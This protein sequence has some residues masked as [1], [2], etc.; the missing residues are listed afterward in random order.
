M[1]HL[2]YVHGFLSAPQSSKAQYTGAWLS[3]QHP[4]W[5]FHC[6]AVSSYPDVANG[7]IETLLQGLPLQ[8]TGLIG[9]SLG[10]FWATRF[11]ERFNLPAALINPAVAPHTRF[12]HWIGQPL[13]SYYGDAVYTLEARH[14]ALLGEFDVATITRPENF[15]VMVQT[16]DETL[17]YRQAV[18]RYAGCK[19][20]VEAGGSHTFDGYEQWLPEILR[21]MG[22]RLGQAHA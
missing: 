15:W 6:P 5:Q 2:V 13:Q 20:T 8:E 11:A 1:R 22:E 12:Q 10:G 4:E 9:S 21:F 14:L 16:G 19:Q 18:A 7:Q 3:A 17:D